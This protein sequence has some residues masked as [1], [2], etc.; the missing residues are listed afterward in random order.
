[1][2]LKSHPKSYYGIFTFFFKSKLYMLFLFY[3]TV[4]LF[5]AISFSFFY[6]LVY[7]GPVN[8]T[9]YKI[10][11]LHKLYY[12]IIT[13]ISPGFTEFL[14]INN[15]SRVISSINGLVGITFNAFFLS[16]L[17]ARALQPHEP[18][19]IVPF[20]LYDPMSKKLSSR[21]YSTLPDNC[22]NLS[23]RLF[24]FAMYEDS[25]GRQF[26]TTLEIKI[27][28][29]YRNVLLPN[30]GIHI[31]AQIDMDHS[32][33]NASLL[34]KH[35]RKKIPIEWLTTD[36]SE[37]QDGHFY[38]TIEAETPYGKTFQT[39]YYYLNKNDIKIGRHALLN[40]GTKL[41]LENWYNWKIYRWDLWGKYTKI[42][43]EE[44]PKDDPIIRRYK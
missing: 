15:Y 8:L 37:Y 44:L 1:M 7:A 13:F 10:T 22:Y 11:W 9:P 36:K 16:V 43:K 21:F 34:R 31:G 42:P 19:N 24:R 4:S 5:I 2:I 32:P 30:Y 35:I 28:P 3:L 33:Q 29:H 41:S 17:V 27:S 23:I 38:I 14:P 20:I 26:G 6:E 39:Q 12:S 40:E 25:L 18:F